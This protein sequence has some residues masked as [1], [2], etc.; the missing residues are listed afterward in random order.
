[1][2]NLLTSKQAADYLGIKESTL[3][4]YR[5]NMITYPLSSPTPMIRFRK[6]GGKVLYALEDLDAYI[7]QQT[8][9]K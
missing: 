3:R 4:M 7:K 2:T 5:S 1:M 9:G 8:R 6:I